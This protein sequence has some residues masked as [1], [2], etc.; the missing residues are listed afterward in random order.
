MS[1]DITNR[2]AAVVTGVLH[3]RP[4][5]GYQAY[6]DDYISAYSATSLG[7]DVAAAVVEELHLQSTGHGHYAWGE[8]L[9][10][11]GWIPDAPAS[12]AR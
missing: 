6:G 3:D 5:V 7:N 11:G 2:I 10:I 8:G 12:P 4:I 9:G 1:D